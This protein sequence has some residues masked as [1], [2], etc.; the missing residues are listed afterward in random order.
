M[1][2]RLAARMSSNFIYFALYMGRIIG[3]PII[4]VS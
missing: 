2:R 4:T 3:I 1:V